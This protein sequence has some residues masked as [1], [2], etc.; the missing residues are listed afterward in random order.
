VP[1]M[2]MVRVEGGKKTKA[3]AYFLSEQASGIL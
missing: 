3:A 2:T 1:N